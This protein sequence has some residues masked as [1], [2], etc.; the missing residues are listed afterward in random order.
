[1]EKSTLKKLVWGIPAAII[2]IAIIVTVALYSPDIPYELTAEQ[3]LNEL[4]NKDNFVNQEAVGQL[5][6]TAKVVFI[7]VR[8]QKEYN[9]RHFSEAI[10]VPAEKI[11]NENYLESIRQMEQEGNSIVI[12]GTVPNQAVGP[13]MLL[14]Q[15]GITSVKMFDGTFE[16]LMSEQQLSLTI[17]NEVPLIDTSALN[18]KVEI[19]KVEVGKAKAP[20]TE[21]PKKVVI[22]TRVEPEPESGGGC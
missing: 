21:A 7:D 15:I 12:Y 14:K 17:N 3:T 22:P 4:S 5:K 16:Q 8:N 20:K 6:N 19:A 1:M 2:T 11:L 13:W 18:K 10:N 9:F